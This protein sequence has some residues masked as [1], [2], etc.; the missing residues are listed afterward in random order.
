MSVFKKTITRRTPSNAERFRRDGC[1]WVRWTDGQ[2]KRQTARVS[3]SGKGVLMQSRTYFARFRDADGHL[4]ERNTGC[5]DRD[6]AL[7]VMHQWQ[8]P[9][10]LL[11]AGLVTRGDIEVA[12]HGNRPIEEQIGA[13]LAWLR[14]AGR[15]ADYVEDVARNLRGIAGACGF[16]RLRDVT[17]SKLETHLASRRQSGEGHRTNNKRLGVWIAFFHFLVRDER[18]PSNPLAGMR[19]TNER[20]DRRR[21]RR[22]LSVEELERLIEAARVRPLHEFI[23]G[24]GATPAKVSAATRQRLEY[25]GA[26]RALAYRV[27]ALTGLRLGE[28]RSIRCSQVV[29]DVEQPYIELRAADEKA[30]RGARVAVQASL[31]AELAQH[32]AR[33]RSEALGHPGVSG[34]MLA[35]RRGDDDPVLFVLNQKLS[36]V[37]AKDLAFAGIERTDAQGR[38][39]DVHCLRH[40]FGTMLARSGVPLQVAQRA[41]RHSDPKLTANV[42]THLD[43]GDMGAAVAALPALGSGSRSRN[44]ARLAGATCLFEGKI[45]TT[46]TR[47]HDGACPVSYQQKATKS[48]RNK[49]FLGEREGGNAGTGEGGR[50]LDPWIHNPVL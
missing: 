20:V 36:R 4:V 25:A 22:A 43:L 41:M 10:E 37:F 19:K 9:G 21:V 48:L 33:R 26:A 40:T 17:R 42:Y 18:M 16:E 5:A 44:V 23:H 15:T 32:I 31:V 2:G 11:R 3:G 46:D 29:L 27:M 39:L 24:S 1:D 7:R 30:R 28:L 14:G 8:T 13:Y 45:D 35:F 12:D 49:G 47:N 50:T 34:N 38:V 6:A